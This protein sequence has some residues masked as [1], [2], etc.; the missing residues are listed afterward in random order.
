M[1]TSLISVRAAPLVPFLASTGRVSLLQ[2]LALA[3]PLAMDVINRGPLVLPILA[4][5]LVV[6]LFWENLFAFLR[7]ADMSL[8]GLTTAML[9][10]LFVPLDVEAW[11]LAFAM[12]LGVVLGELVFGGRG[13]GFVHPAAATLALLAFS[14]PQLSLQPTAT[15]VALASVASAALLLLAGLISWRVLLATSA[16]AGA[17]LAWSGGLVSVQ[18]LLIPVSA[19]LIFLIADALSATATNPGRWAYGA[20]AGFLIAVFAGFST[21]QLSTEA[22]VFAALLASVF[23]PLIDH[24][25]VLANAYWRENRRA[26][27]TKQ[28]LSNESRGEADNG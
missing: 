21:D 11:Q 19:G 28:R 7:H 6:A 18:A 16:V 24:L 8:H 22:V 1:R 5:A 2:A 15:S 12:S 13:F 10:T 20:L 14:F 25:A 23:A 3:V 17:A 27:R 4:T 26:K 9:V